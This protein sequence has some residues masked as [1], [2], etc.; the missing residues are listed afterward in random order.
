MCEANGSSITNTVIGVCRTTPSMRVLPQELSIPTTAM[1]EQ[2]PPPTIRTGPTPFK[3]P[4][5]RILTKTPCKSLHL[6][7]FLPAELRIKIWLG[8]TDTTRLL[9]LDLAIDTPPPLIHSCYESRALVKCMYT[10]HQ[11]RINVTGGEEELVPTETQSY[12]PFRIWVN[13]HGQ[14]ILHLT[15]LARH[16]LDGPEYYPETPSVANRNLTAAYMLRRV[17]FTS[18]RTSTA[19]KRRDLGIKKIMLESGYE[20]QNRIEEE[21][22]WSFAYATLMYSRKIKING[23]VPEELIVV[24]RDNYLDT[25]R[26][27]LSNLEQRAKCVIRGE[28]KDCCDSGFYFTGRRGRCGVVPR[29][30]DMVLGARE[31]Q[32]VFHVAVGI[33]MAEAEWLPTGA[34]YPVGPDVLFFRERVKTS[35]NEKKEMRRIEKNARQRDR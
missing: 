23:L 9:R 34:E 12:I 4:S 21:D 29:V 17:E 11:G 2:Q 26:L 30:E 33:E 13:K 25:S 3:A 15:P 5:R 32:A 31:E 35:R 27:K 1:Q 18:R 20:Q 14:D 8:A 16:I 19:Y 24:W 22:C 7:S 28:E 10:M 6:F